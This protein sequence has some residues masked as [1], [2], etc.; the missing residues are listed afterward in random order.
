MKRPG[1]VAIA[2]GLLV[3][4]AAGAIAQEYDRYEEADPKN[5]VAYDGRFTFARIKYQ[6]SPRGYTQEGLLDTKWNHDYPRAERH[7]SMILRELTAVDLRAD[8]SVLLTLDDPEL[9]KYPIAFMWEPG[10]WNLT[11]RE[12]RVHTSFLKDVAP[13]PGRGFSF[14]IRTFF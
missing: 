4:T 11:D 12:A 10:F 3:A 9:F 8:D 6:I 2:C 13:L 5:N 7:L 14:G 1:R